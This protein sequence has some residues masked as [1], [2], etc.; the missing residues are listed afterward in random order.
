MRTDTG[1]QRLHV[2]VDI[3]GAGP[4]RV[5][6]IVR[7]SARFPHL[8][9]Q[10]LRVR[11]LAGDHSASFWSVLLNGSR[12]EWVQREHEEPGPSLHFAQ[13]EGDFEEL[14]GRWTV[15]ET[16]GGSRLS[17]TIEF[18]LGVDGLA[19]L[20]NPIWAQSLQAYAEALV[21]AIADTARRSAR[22]EAAIDH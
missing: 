9:D 22:G 4:A 2:A 20:L 10:V 18:H 15:E 11:P 21:T 8:T 1:M 12:V 19:P 7:N 3:D 13:T 16:D 6:R 14:R 5:W 17:L